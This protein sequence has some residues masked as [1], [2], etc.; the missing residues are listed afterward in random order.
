M[1]LAAGADTNLADHDGWTPLHSCVYYELSELV[2]MLLKAGANPR[3]RDLQG[4]TPEEFATS[5]GHH[6]MAKLLHS[7]RYKV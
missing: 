4:D 6:K 7:Q 1:L 3:Q 2:P 5:L